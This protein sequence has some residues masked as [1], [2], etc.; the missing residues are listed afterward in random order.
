MSTNVEGRAAK[1]IP[2]VEGKIRDL[3]A[4]KAD[5]T[6]AI[7]V[8]GDDPFAEPVV[9]RV[10]QFAGVEAV[11]DGLIGRLHSALEAWKFVEELNQANAVAPSLSV[12]DDGDRR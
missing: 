9:I 12:G 10:G 3:E 2:Y 11:L 1:M 4:L 8:W 7:K 5:K 6:L